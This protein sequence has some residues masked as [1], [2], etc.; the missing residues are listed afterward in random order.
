MTYYIARTVSTSFDETVKKV[1]EALKE[2]GFG[3]LTD[4]DVAETLKAKLDVEFPKYR[5]LGACN[6][7]LALRALL[8]ENKI[9]TLLPCNVIV[10][11]TGRGDTEVAAVDPVVSLS[12]VGQAELEP[13]ANEVRTRLE[14]MLASL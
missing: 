1:I 4:I 9:G 12:R 3:V 13:V 2:E 8:Q 10:R 11:D 6:P 14:R 5:I 7:G